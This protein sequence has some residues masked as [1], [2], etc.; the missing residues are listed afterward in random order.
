LS[1]RATTSPHRLRGASIAGSQAGKAVKD[2]LKGSS[3][4]EE[5]AQNWM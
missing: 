1:T 5:D 2:L 4:E 3:E